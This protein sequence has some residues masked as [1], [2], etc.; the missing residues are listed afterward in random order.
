MEE[1]SKHYLLVTTTK[2]NSMTLDVGCVESYEEM[3]NGIISLNFKSGRS[4]EV[5]EELDQEVWNGDSVCTIIDAY[6]SSLKNS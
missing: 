3:G 6:I 1:T 5:K 4:V 2:G